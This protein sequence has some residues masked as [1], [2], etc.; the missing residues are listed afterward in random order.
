MEELVEIRQKII[1]ELDL[2][3][4]LTLG[5]GENQERAAGVTGWVVKP[6]KHDQ[7]VGVVDPLV[8]V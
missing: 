7:L 5:K 3:L 2:R 4:S 8:S 1:N 6:F